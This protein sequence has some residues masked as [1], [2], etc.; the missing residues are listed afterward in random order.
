LTF[1]RLRCSR[2][3]HKMGCWHIMET[4]NRALCGA[5][6]VTKTQYWET[7]DPIEGYCHNCRIIQEAKE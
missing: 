6:Q 3:P 7:G 4:D 2:F 1:A 5:R